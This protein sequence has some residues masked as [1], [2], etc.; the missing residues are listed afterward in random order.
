MKNSKTNILR[1][2]YSL[3]VVFACT[4]ISLGPVIIPRWDQLLQQHPRKICDG[5]WIF[6]QD[7]PPPILKHDQFGSR[8]SFLSH[9]CDSFLGEKIILDMIVSVQSNHVS[10]LL[11]LV[12]T[13][14]VAL[15]LF[16][17]VRGCVIVFVCLAYTLPCPPG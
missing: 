17:P 15:H 9:L 13:V 3:L 7:T 5:Q 10:K 4:R 6:L 12:K 16:G 8:L 2:L 11:H 1:D 14:C